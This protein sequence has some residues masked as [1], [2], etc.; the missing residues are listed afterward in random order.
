MYYSTVAGA[1]GGERAKI[2]AFIN[3]FNNPQ[4]PNKS[5]LFACFDVADLHPDLSVLACYIPDIKW[6]S[7]LQEVWEMM[8]YLANLAGLSYVFKRVGRNFESFEQYDNHTQDFF[9]TRLLDL[10][11]VRI[12]CELCVHAC[13]DEAFNLSS[14]KIKNSSAFD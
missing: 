11:K 8:C 12:N 3:Q 5:E 10:F 7:K 14:G 2:D 6:N 9:D 13:L 1:I 4:F